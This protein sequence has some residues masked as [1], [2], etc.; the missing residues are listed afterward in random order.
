MAWHCYG[1]MEVM[2]QFHARYPSV[3][4]IMSECSPGIVPYAP[5]EI[6]ITALRNWA[7]GVDLWNLAQD[8]AGGPVQP[9]N[10][11]CQ[12][13]VGLVRVNESTHT[14]AL[15]RSYFQLGQLSRFI[16]PGAVRVGTE[17]WVSDFSGQPGA[18]YGTTPGLDNVA[19]VNPGG[20][21]VLVAYN[22]APQTSSF[23]VSWHHRQFSYRLAS[24]ATVTFSWR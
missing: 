7:T 1:G 15:T 2:S 8:P 18:R 23:A 17:R 12:H 20:Q 11:A 10:P 9:L 13:C 19:V 4:E 14:A 22:S 24:R 3:P 6:G 5:A 21:H 16:S